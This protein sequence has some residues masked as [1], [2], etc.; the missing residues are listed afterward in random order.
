MTAWEDVLETGDIKAA[1]YLIASG[2]EVNKKNGEGK[3]LLMCAILEGH[4]DIVELLL[5]SGSDI[6]AKDEYGKTPLMY[7]VEYADIEVIL[8]L[9]EKGADIEAVDSFG[10]T[11]L[12]YSKE[13]CNN[14]KITK[15]L[16]KYWADKNQSSSDFTVFSKKLTRSMNLNVLSHFA[17]EVFFCISLKLKSFLP[18]PASFTFL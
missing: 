5:E 9:I 3:T 11:V 13:S 12:D 10:K 6:N 1:R 15:I 18:L 17:K 14:L 4:T 16:K 8:L 2:G 7:A